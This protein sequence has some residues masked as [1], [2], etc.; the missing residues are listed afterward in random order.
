MRYWAKWKKRSNVVM[1]NEMMLAKGWSRGGLPTK[2]MWVS[3]LLTICVAGCS[4]SSDT[5]VSENVV[6]SESSTATPKNTAASEGVSSSS[7]VSGEAAKYDWPVFHGTDGSNVSTETGLLKQWSADGPKLL[8]QATELGNGFSTVSIHQGR[9]AILGTTPDEKTALFV[10]DFDGNRLYQ[11]TLDDEWTENFNGSR[12]TPTWYGDKIY[13]ETPR[14]LV[15]CMNAADGSIVWQ[16]DLVKEYSATIHTWGRAESPVVDDGRLIVAPFTEKLSFVGLDLDTG[17]EVFRGDPVQGIASYTTPQIVTHAGTRMILSMTTYGFVGVNAVTGAKLFDYPKT[18]DFN[19]L[20]TTPLYHDGQ[21]FI[22]SGYNT[23]CVMLKITGTGMSDAPFGLEKVWESLTIDNQHG[24][25]LRLGERIYGAAHRW[26]KRPNWYAINWSDGSVVWEN[27]SVGQ[28]AL[29]AA[30]GRLYL[31][32]ENEKT[33]GVALVD[34]D[35]NEYRECGRFALPDNREQV[36]IWAHP[37][38]CCGRLFVRHGGTLYCYEL[39]T[40]PT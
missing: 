36:K 13:V 20:A 8:W 9:I 11:Q 1:T 21:V 14:G 24:G 16:R 6:A 29:T 12:S 7:S 40:D 17:K 35:A 5:V 19:I 10:Y 38:I 3:L 33:R 25:V 22:S 4:R 30:D 37:V 18:T 2:W 23:S 34:A 27:P 39:R 26:G 15:V 28:G 32:S 31:V